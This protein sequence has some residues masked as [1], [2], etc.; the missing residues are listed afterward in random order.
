MPPTPHDIT[1]MLLTLVLYTLQ[2]YQDVTLDTALRTNPLSGQAIEILVDWLQSHSS[3]NLNKLLWPIISEH[4]EQHGDTTGIY[5]IQRFL[6]W[7]NTDGN[8][9]DV[10]YEKIRLKLDHDTRNW[11]GNQDEGDY[12]NF[13]LIIYDNDTQPNIYITSPKAIH[14]NSSLMREDGTILSTQEPITQHEILW[15]VD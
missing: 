2:S 15:R 10:L 9:V 14:G 3:V 13:V 1:S 5:V 4:Y 6:G 7:L 8:E 12:S 11:P